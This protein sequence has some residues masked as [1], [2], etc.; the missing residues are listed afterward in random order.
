MP[1]EIRVFIPIVRVFRLL[2]GYGIF[3]S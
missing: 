1:S 3:S 2:T